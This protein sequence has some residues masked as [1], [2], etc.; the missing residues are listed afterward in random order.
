MTSDELVDATHL[1][2]WAKFVGRS[3]GDPLSCLMELCEQ[4]STDSSH[5]LLAPVFRLRLSHAATS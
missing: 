2:R 4:L 3:D 1:L 5:F